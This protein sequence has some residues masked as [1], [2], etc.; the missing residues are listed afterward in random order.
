[1]LYSFC[2][3]FSFPFSHLSSGFLLMY[4][5][6]TMSMNK[7]YVTLFYIIFVLSLSPN[8]L[9]DPQG[10]ELCFICP[11]PWMSSKCGDF[12]FVLC[13]FFFLLLWACRFSVTLLFYYL[14]LARLLMTWVLLRLY[15]EGF[16]SILVLLYNIHIIV[17]K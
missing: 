10:E 3:V 13:L 1:M 4:C 17:S 8:R 12:L 11:L 6:S 5:H 7:A 9:E 14:L 15:S 2:E 16:N